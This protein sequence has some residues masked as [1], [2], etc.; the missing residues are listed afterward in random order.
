MAK[1]RYGSN[2]V[3]YF[4][5]TSKILLHGFRQALFNII[6][7]M[8]GTGYA[9]APYDTWGSPV[10]VIFLVATFLGGCAGSAACGIKMFRL[11]ISFKAVFAYAAQI[12]RPN[13][14][15]RVR[16][17]GRVVSSDTLQSVMVFVFLYMAT[18]IIATVLLSMTGMDMLS[19]I[20][21]ARAIPPR[22][23]PDQPTRRPPDGT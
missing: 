23:F 6:S 13:R 10:V 11:E 14:V 18:F 19:A 12:V 20:S 2:A 3:A 5:H 16:Y 4:C 1:S 22:Q 17:A 21:G 9:S 8:T 7:I 15:V